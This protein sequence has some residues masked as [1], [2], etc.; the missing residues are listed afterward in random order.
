MQSQTTADRCPSC[1]KR[2]GK[3]SGAGCFK[4]ALILGVLGLLL[5]AGCVAIVGV[6]ADEVSKELDRQQN[7]NAISQSEFASIT[8]GDSQDDIEAQYGEP[9]DKQEFENEGILDEEPANSSCIYYNREGGDFGD[10]YQLCFDEG[11]LTS[12]NSY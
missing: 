1:G 10:I 2:Y 9:A 5:I 8:L 3:K 7:E 4:W 12:K 11:R 6:G